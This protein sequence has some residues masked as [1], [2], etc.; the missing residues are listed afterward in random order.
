MISS[1]EQRPIAAPR[2]RTRAATLALLSLAAMLVAGSARAQYYD[3]R[4]DYY[5]GYPGPR[6]FYRDMPERRFGPEGD[7]QPSSALSLAQIRELVSRRGLHLVATPRRKGRIY[8]AESEDAHGIRH[9]LVFD[10]LDGRLI[11]N[12]VLGPKRPIPGDTGKNVLDQAKGQLPTK[13]PPVD[14]ETPPDNPPK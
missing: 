9:R 14:G 2:A 1:P 13:T 7:D 4:E 12:T 10:A 3:W 8:L 11:E 6:D 5:G